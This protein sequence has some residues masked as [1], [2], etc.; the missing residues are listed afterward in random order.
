MGVSGNRLIKDYSG[1]DDSLGDVSEFSKG[2]QMAIENRSVDLPY[3]HLISNR[4]AKDTE[5]SL[6]SQIYV[7]RTC[8]EIQT[9]NKIQID[10]F[11]ILI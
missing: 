11:I 7:K 4:K 9:R 1:F 5:M 10:Y 8:L 2:A 3:N 6:Q